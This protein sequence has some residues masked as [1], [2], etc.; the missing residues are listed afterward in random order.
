MDM[1]VFDSALRR[2]SRSGVD[3]ME[4]SLIAPPN[5]SDQWLLTLNLLRALIPAKP[6][7]AWCR[8]PPD[9]TAFGERDPAAAGNR[10][11]GAASSFRTSAAT[12]LC[13]PN[14]AGDQRYDQERQEDE[15]QNLRYPGRSSRY[16]AET[17]C[18]G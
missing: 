1:P 5:T 10:L 9:P 7:M 2:L 17:K 6:S 14:Q 4:C 8:V 11:R 15:E 3:G 16:A 12:R 13:A 18:A